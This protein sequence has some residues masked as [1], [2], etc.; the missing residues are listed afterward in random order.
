[1][2]MKEIKKQLFS[3]LQNGRMGKIVDTTFRN[4]IERL[5]PEGFL[6]ES[7]TGYYKGEFPRSAG[8]YA[9]L[10][11]E[12]GRPELGRLAISY[13]FDTVKALSLPRIPHVIGEGRSFIDPIDQIDGS[14]HNILGYARLCIEAPDEDFEDKY[15]EYCRREIISYY[16]FP[17]FYFN[18]AHA[19]SPFASHR[20]GLIFNMQY[21]HDREDRLWACFDMVTQ[22]FVGAAGD[23]MLR[24]AE[25]RG[26]GELAEILRF[27]TKAHREGVEK[28]MTF[29]V[30]G[31]KLYMEMRLPDSNFGVPYSAL[32]FTNYGPIAAGWEGINANILEATLDHIEKNVSYYDASSDSTILMQ[33]YNP[34]GSL[35][36]QTYGKAIAWMLEHQRLK[37]EFDKIYEWFKF[38]NYYHGNNDI[39]CEMFYMKDGKWVFRDYGNGEQCIWFC[40]M[41]LR[42][43]RELEEELS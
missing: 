22:S 2:Y 26:D 11:L 35:D 19:T 17:Y 40:M 24:L 25:K 6:P 34:D 36:M 16:D 4:L 7:L 9:L 37:G 12:N 29:D 27:R 21:E 20:L 42:L 43:R 28:Y 1:M 32:G 39:L 8:C 38:F 15:Y 18:Y 5:S 3:E 14:A 41:L 31:K 10:M 33:E 23:A 13:V 30:E